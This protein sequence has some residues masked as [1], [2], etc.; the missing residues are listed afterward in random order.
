MTFTE[1]K[2]KPGDYVWN[3]SQ[4]QFV[5]RI[6]KDGT[7]DK[8]FSKGG[9]CSM[10]NNIIAETGYVPTNPQQFASK[11][12][13]HK[14][15]DYLV[16]GYGV[17]VNCYD[18]S[19]EMWAAKA[20]EHL[21]IEG[22]GIA[23]I[24]ACV[25]KSKETEHKAKIESLALIFGKELKSKKLGD[26]VQVSEFEQRLKQER[27]AAS[28]QRAE[29]ED[30]AKLRTWIHSAFQD[31]KVLL[32][33]IFHYCSNSAGLGDEWLIANVVLP[34]CRKNP[35]LKRAVC[36]RYEEEHQHLF[37]EFGVDS[38]AGYAQEYIH[39]YCT[40]QEW[41]AY[42]EMEMASPAVLDNPEEFQKARAKFLR[43]KRN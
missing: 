21:G 11:I 33:V 15:S 17:L 41:D 10:L 34:W 36:K 31:K 43:L 20:A 22:N 7:E 35:F 14:Q 2:A 12:A 42:K 13:D 5:G 40:E 25:S 32:K 18:L 9:L 30:Q 27:I 16:K 26:L 4:V 38:F 23:D 39:R 6:N 3:E 29:E 8:R 37:K 28:R 1:L 24:L 19:A